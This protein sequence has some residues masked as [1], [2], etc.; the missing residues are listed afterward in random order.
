MDDTPSDKQPIRVLYCIL[1]NRF[2]GPHR[3]AQ[4]VARRLR[5]DGIETLFLTGH[6]GGETW[7]PDGFPSYVCKHI[8]CFRRRSPIRNFLVFSVMLPYTLWRL[9]GIIRS[10]AIDIVHV[11]GV[12]NFVPAL[13]AWLTGRRIVWLYNDYLPRPLRPVLMPLITRLASTFLVQGECLKRQYTAGN[14]RLR[15]KAV[16]LYSCTDVSRFTPDGQSTEL[17]QRIRR[18]FGIPADCLFVGTI[19]N[20]NRFK[21]ITYFIEAAGRVKSRVPSAKFAVVGRRLDTDPEYWDQVQQLTEQLGLKQD[22][23]FTG[24]CEDIPAILSA[25]DVFVLAS[26]EESCPVALLEAMAMKVPVVATS[27]GAVSE[28]VDHGRTGFVVPPGDAGAIAEAV[29]AIVAKPRDQVRNMV[30]E[31][32]KTVEREFSVDIIARQQKEIYECLSGRARLSDTGVESR[33]PLGRP[34][35]H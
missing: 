6:K 9:C 13:A 27:V 1:D 28:M 29:L 25:L 18:Q 11:D 19:R 35:R 5:E 23:V 24:F 8:Q 32:R 17:R 30:E 21:G 16:V 14:P 2:G 34:D 12:T 7:R 15:D 4:A 10:N 3:L 31:A 22:V 26:I 33:R 20:V